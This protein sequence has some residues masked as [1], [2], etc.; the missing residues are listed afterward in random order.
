[1]QNIKHKASPWLFVTL[2]IMLAAVVAVSYFYNHSNRAMP[3]PPSRDNGV[4]P[5]SVKPSPHVVA[6]YSVA[7]DQPK[8]ITIPAIS[9]QQTRIRQLGLTKDNRMAAPNNIYDAGWYKQ[10]SRPGQAGAMFI[11]GHVSSWQA[12]GAFYN[13]KK[14]QPGDSITVTRGDDKAFTYKVVATKTYPYDKVD[15]NAVL[16]PVNGSITGMNLMTCT[17]KIIKGTSEFDQRLVVF[18]T[19]A[20][21]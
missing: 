18:T 4:M 20:D 11:Y 6:D 15:M 16:S 7:P 14:L 9:S 5:S 19:L 17:G 2:C 13:V 12:Y 1:M 10:S 21:N 8:Y 3:A